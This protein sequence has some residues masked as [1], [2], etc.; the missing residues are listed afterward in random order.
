M[1][2]AAGLGVA[3]S[4][5][6]LAGI[7][8]L[9]RFQT[10][11]LFPIVRDESGLD[12]A[13]DDGGD[14][15]EDG[16]IAADSGK[17]SVAVGVARPK[18][19]V[20]PPSSV[21][22][23]F[24]IQ[25]GAAEIQLIPQAVRFELP[26][27][28][29]RN[30]FEEWQRI[31]LGAADNEARSLKSPPAGQAQVRID[32]I[33]LFDGRARLDVLWRAR[34]DGWLVTVSLSNAQRL[35]PKAPNSNGSAEARNEELRQRNNLALFEV[36]LECV[37]D[38]GRIGPY[39]R[40]DFHLLGL[41]E[42]ELELRYR[43]RIIYAIGHGA[44]V[45][46]T[47]REGRVVSL[48]TEFL[49]KVEVPR[50]D[51]TAGEA[52]GAELG[53]ERLAMI[54]TD[55]DQ[56]CTALQ[57]FVDGYCAW[58]ATQA[59]SIDGLASRYR[60]PAGRILARM[61]DASARMRAGV[62]LLRSNP[63]VARA[64][65]LANAA[66]ASQMRQAIPRWRPF[67]LAF[68]LLTLESAID[69]DAEHR[70]VLDLIWFPTGGGKT[71]AYLGLMA[72]VIWWRRLKYKA[73][74]G[75]TTVLMR[76]TLRLLTK[77]QF[78]RAARLI[79]AMELMRRKQPELLGAEPVTLG[80]WVGG[81]SSPNSFAAAK[82]AV[83]DAIADEQTRPPS[84]LVLESCPWCGTAFSVPDN[85][86]AG[87]QHF[88]FR[89]THAACDF[90][91][92]EG[93][94]LPCN[95]V[96]EALYRAPPTLL[97]ATIDK[98]ARLAWEERSS[99]FFG[100]GRNRPPE[101]IIQDELHLIAGALGSVA[102]LYE[103]G[104]ETV[105]RMRG[106]YPKYVASTATIRMAN[107]QVRRLYGRETAVFPPPGLDA[108]D[109]YFARNIAPTR[110][111]PG[112]LYVGYL[113]PDR[114]RQRCLAPLAA[115][116]LSAPEALFGDAASDRDALLDAWW[117][118][119][120]YH[121]S[122][123]GV[124]VSRNALREIEERID[125]LQRE[126]RQQQP[127][128]EAPD[129]Q[130]GSPADPEPRWRQQLAERLTQL[131]SQMSADENARGFERLAKTREDPDCLDL[132]LATNMVS[133]GLD[134]PRLSVM[135]I[136]GQPLTTAEYIQASSRV[137]RGEVPGIVVAN[138]YRDQARSLSHYEDFRA[139][140]EAFYR[141]VEPTSVTPYTYQ[142]RLRALHAALV[143]AVRHAN[144]D[145]TANE[146]AQAFD[147]GRPETGKVIEELIKRCRCADPGR[148]DETA[149]HIRR[150]VEHWADTARRAGEQQQR[151]VY[152]GPDRDRRDLR[153]LY[154]HDARVPGEW[155][156]L[157]NMR[158]VEN[159]ALIKI[160]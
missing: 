69:P 4:V 79:C 158:N 46:W 56:I 139:Y 8:P 18:R 130:P 100:C 141:F 138:Y 72:L 105:L 149:A 96:D 33:A 82:Q 7:K 154:S 2:P 71:E 81:A 146:R 113:A 128:A 93:V 34:S 53:V 132:A 59:S 49:P 44:A 1:G 121:G 12:P 75:G 91:R 148:G 107:E 27:D 120:V 48:R 14:D 99:A 66:M 63:L 159:T 156:T 28:R 24:F 108:D 13:D 151:L 20:V 140:H 86:D 98:F 62:E 16:L 129:Q 90:G 42:Q 106:M 150:L 80:L 35:P 126:W 29:K 40:A 39:P 116:L 87:A 83:D 131:T 127:A 152:A 43:E 76:Y 103:A 89:C 9:E 74:G 124:G 117:T 144:D 70:D 125:R 21:G 52:V 78:R 153:L 50:F 15:A 142:A 95:V 65:G 19:R 26:A 118:L 25:G 160:L 68:L 58:I 22:F 11:I 119:L 36:A 51:P 123:K 115:A 102:G 5:K 145:L 104:L 147:P 155:V 92:A 73:S 94:T 17:A 31:T 143:I 30:D 61:E 77:D 45:D 133:V 112:R 122:L 109:A 6:P 85:F 136:N 101:L 111:R 137:G 55:H 114:N 67:Q 23:S 47:L 135:I 84:L 134:V 97:L 10:A 57:R 64:F 32:P 60:E 37:I 88:H 41:E 54:E 110:E 38:T 3:M 157:H